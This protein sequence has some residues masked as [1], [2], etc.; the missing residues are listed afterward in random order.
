MNRPKEQKGCA[1]CGTPVP[2]HDD[3]EV[4]VRSSL[5]PEC[6]DTFETESHR[7]THAHDVRHPHND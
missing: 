7:P 4:S 3:H 1:W 2:G 6:D 5:C